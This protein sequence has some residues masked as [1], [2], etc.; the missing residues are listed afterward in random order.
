MRSEGEPMW[1]MAFWILD[2]Q[3]QR[4]A[5]L[6]ILDKTRLVA[7]TD[8]MT[9]VGRR[10]GMACLVSLCPAY[11]NSS[12]MKWRLTPLRRARQ[13]MQALDRG[14]PTIF[15]QPGHLSLEDMLDPRRMEETS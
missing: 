15:N 8:Y 12:L 5:W 6:R 14:T 2:A 4:S 9:V 7:D 13:L 1:R 3:R 10:T 11:L